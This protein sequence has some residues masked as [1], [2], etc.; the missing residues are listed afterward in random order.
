MDV[1]AAGPEVKHGD[2]VTG[3]FQVGL[4]GKQ[5]APQ[6]PARPPFP[7]LPCLLKG[8]GTQGCCSLIPFPEAASLSCSFLAP[9]PPTPLGGADGS[10]LLLAQQTPRWGTRPLS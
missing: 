6:L 5:A 1:L 2:T 7:R 4:P 9:P 3:V 10:L 8:P